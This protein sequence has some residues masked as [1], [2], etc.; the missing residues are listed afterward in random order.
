MHYSSLVQI[1]QKLIEMGIPK[2]S[3]LLKDQTIK[4]ETDPRTSLGRTEGSLY[5]L[6]VEGYDTEG[7]TTEH[8]DQHLIL[9]IIDAVHKGDTYEKESR[10]LGKQRSFLRVRL[11]KN[12]GYDFVLI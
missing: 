11:D 10:F 4:V 8:A 3:I 2:E 9:S 1:E 5:E 12:T 6:N 7:W